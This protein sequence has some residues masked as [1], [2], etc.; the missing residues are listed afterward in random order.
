M[1][2]LQPHLRTCLRKIHLYGLH[3]LIQPLISWKRTMTE[4]PILALPNF[5]EEFVLETDASRLGIGVILSQHGHP[6]CYYSKKFGP[7]MMSTSTY[8]HET[9]AITSAS[10]NGALICW[11]VNSLSLLISAS[12][13]S[14]WHKLFRHLSSSFI[15]L[16]FSDILMKFRTSRVPKIEWQMHFPVLMSHLINYW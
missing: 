10:R 16:S 4:A 1:Y 13:E 3:K 15:W 14:L 11:V 2:L 7:R 5:D 9:C 8:V 12:S 6:I